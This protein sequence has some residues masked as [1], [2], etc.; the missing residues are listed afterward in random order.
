MAFTGV[1]DQKSSSDTAL[2]PLPET[3]IATFGKFTG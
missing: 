2:L 3:N 1:L